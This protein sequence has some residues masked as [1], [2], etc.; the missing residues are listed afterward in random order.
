[1]LPS[2][3]KLSERLE[4]VCATGCC[5]VRASIELLEQ[6]KPVQFTEDLD[7]QERELLLHE[8]KAIMA[9]YDR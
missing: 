1:M 8:L 5:A 9:V 4:A 6:G 7:Q 3:H 2:S